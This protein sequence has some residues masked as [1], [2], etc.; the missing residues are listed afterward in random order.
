MSDS[1]KMQLQFYDA[2][3]RSV[4][5]VKVICEHIGTAGRLSIYRTLEPIMN[6]HENYVYYE[7]V[8]DNSC[9]RKVRVAQ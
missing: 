2:G 7:F 5:D 4:D 9:I 8:C 1:T 6:Q 3:I